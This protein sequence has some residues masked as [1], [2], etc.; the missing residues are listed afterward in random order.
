MSRASRKAEWLTSIFWRMIARLSKAGE[1][2][3]TKHQTTGRPR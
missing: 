2:M 3:T 1:R